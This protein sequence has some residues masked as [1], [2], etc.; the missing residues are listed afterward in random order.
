MD[1]TFEEKLKLLSKSVKNS[2]KAVNR[3]NF[4][5]KKFTKSDAVLV[6]KNSIKLE[7]KKGL[8]DLFD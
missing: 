2:F 6:M 8:N 1:I 7:T 5:T 4:L 3:N